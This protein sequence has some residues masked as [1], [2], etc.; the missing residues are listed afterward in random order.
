METE[1]IINK[2]CGTISDGRF[3]PPI[4]HVPNIYIR[5]SI[6]R[7]VNEAL[8]AAEVGNNVESDPVG[9]A[10]NVPP[11]S[12][13]CDAQLLP[14]FD[15]R[16]TTLSPR[17]R[18]QLSR[19]YDAAQKGGDALTSR[20]RLKNLLTKDI[21][22]TTRGAYLPISENVYLEGKLPSY[23]KLVGKVGCDAGPPFP[24]N[25]QFFSN[26]LLIPRDYGK[27]GI[28]PKS[29]PSPTMRLTNI[30]FL[31]VTLEFDGSTQAHFEEQLSWLRGDEMAFA[32]VDRELCKYKDYRGYCA[33][34]SGNK[35]IHFHFIFSTEHFV[36]APFDATANERLLNI[37]HE[38]PLMDNAHKIYWDEV[39]LAFASI[40]QPSIQPDQ[41][42]RSAVQW[43]RTPWGTRKLEEPS[44]ILGLQEGATVPQIVIRERIRERAPKGASDY[45]IAPAFS[46]STPRSGSSESRRASQI[47]PRKM[48]NELIA[49]VQEEC[50]AE[51]GEYPKP[52]RVSQRNGDW[53]IN[54]QNDAEDC[55]PSS[56]V[57]GDYRCLEICGKNAIPAKRLFLPDHMT[58]NE[59]V[60]H[61]LRRIGQNVTPRET[62]TTQ[63]F[64]TT[65]YCRCSP[66][67]DKFAER[68]EK[69][70]PE[71]F[72]TMS[73]DELKAT[74]RK[75]LALS[76]M[77]S[78]AF[79]KV[80]IQSGEGIGKT[81]ALLPILIEEARDDACVLDANGAQHFAGMAFRS[82]EQVIK[83]AEELVAE[84]YSVFVYRS[85]WDYYEE[86]CVR[87]RETPLPRDGKSTFA[88]YQDIMK[89]QLNVF[90]VLE[91]TRKALWSSCSF[92]GVSTTLLMT[93]KA[94]QTW[95][96]GSFSRAW[97]H[98]DF[99]PISTNE[100]VRA[101]KKQMQLRRVVIDDPE[102]DDFIYIIPEATFQFLNHLHTA[103]PDWRNRPNSERTLIYR[104]MSEKNEIPGNQIR[105]FEDLD[106]LMR[107]T[108][109]TLDRV[110]VDFNR[111][112]YGYDQNDKGIYRRQNGCVFY[113]GAKS[114]PFAKTRSF[115]FLTTENLVTNTIIGSTAKYRSQGNAASMPFSLRLDG[116]NGMYPIR[117]PVEIDRRAK[118]FDIRH[119]ASEIILKNPNAVVIADMVQCVES[120][121]NF[122]TMKGQN[123]LDGRDIYIVPTCLSP[124]QYSELNV[125][126]KWLDMP[127]IIGEYYHDQLNQAVGRN[128]GFRDD[129][130]GLT[131]TVIVTSNRLFKNVLSGPLSNRPRISLYLQ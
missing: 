56:V 130:S 17:D 115:T 15:F 90:R 114:W 113:L 109:S 92:S 67:I 31:I 73:I 42:L 107:V 100:E 35:S 46:P 87:Q 83:K 68:I 22:D 21:Y 27:P 26:G 93:H 2:N 98:P 126:G 131:K 16:S 25:A 58:A 79:D 55:N 32:A 14:D 71:P 104:D 50:A 85:F 28:D 30:G 24:R 19:I 72:T 88:V 62:D 94:A 105:Q 4:R 128:R 38:A 75:K 117:I 120:V 63:R 54:F 97:H 57:I 36:N 122:Q 65:I 108:L 80:I 111:I 49:L 18:D 12:E 33:V 78:R 52:V 8:G 9:V 89:Y 129:L 74:Y 1:E 48:P 34:Y 23:L 13:H 125:L 45:L 123:G 29:F 39:N 61:L 37:H 86:A 77:Q 59:L 116:L 20:S 40:L 127:N 110:T 102:S 106:E 5:D 101:L 121:I 96:D 118:K 6:Y 70:F 43:R 3:V 119:L 84:G 81:S 99:H 11:I 64:P 53:A 91:Q 82:H 69:S 66:V 47:V 112:P 41:S 124:F 44:Q 103:F 51:W 10:A 60:D 76:C 95:D 7:G